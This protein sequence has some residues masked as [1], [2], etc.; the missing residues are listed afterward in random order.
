[1]EKKYA[2]IVTALV[3]LLVAGN[4]IFF[5]FS[6][7]ESERVIVGRAIDGDTLE[8][9]DGR[10]VR[11]LNINTPEKKEFGYEKALNFLKK[12]ENSSVRLE[13]TGTEKYGRLLARVYAP[14]YLNLEIVRLGLGH[15][16]LVDDNERDLFNEAQEEAIEYGGGIWTHSPA[17]GCLRGEINKKDE[18][19]RLERSCEVSI[20]GW[21][22]K[23][24]TTRKYRLEEI[25]AKEFYLYSGKGT[26]TQ[27]NLYWGR[28]SVWNDDR[29][30]VFI[31]DDS[32]LLVF[33]DS[34]GY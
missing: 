31:R 12:Y 16:L 34:Y 28:G 23:D 24:E 21:T 2:L 26:N 7:R 8:L 17:Y 1:M 20:N 3:L 27:D 33:Y 29:D 32:G 4:M 10:I 13:I 30:S 18:Y 11:M 14:N 9:E 22:I 25:S 6:E 19:L 5:G 15:T